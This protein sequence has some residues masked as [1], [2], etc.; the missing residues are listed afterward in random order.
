[1]SERW[2]DRIYNYSTEPPEGMW[3]RIAAELES[4]HSYQDFPQKLY[5]SR[6]DPPTG[7]WQKISEALQNP[8][9]DTVTGVKKIRVWGKFAAAAVLLGFIVWGGVKIFHAANKSSDIPVAENKT[10]VLTNHL[11]LAEQKDPAVKNSLAGTNSANN[12]VKQDRTG[13]TTGRILTIS[14]PSVLSEPRFPDENEL[15]NSG[16]MQANYAV[17][18]R[19]K[20]VLNPDG[21]SDCYIN[22]ATPEG[23]L[24]RLS[25]RFGDLACCVSG[26]DHDP[27]CND[28]M[29][30]WRCRIIQSQVSPSSGSGFI[31]MLNMVKQ[32]SD[33]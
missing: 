10:P 30:N 1:M 21:L 15:I 8:V 31:D 27:S 5:H 28:Q 13:N 11:P 17:N 19:K 33:N 32:L 24:I 25:R 20:I 22:L 9:Q 23:Q 12:I 7:S 6:I 2:R 16:F 14:S 26:E 18:T 29:N 4:S 3:K